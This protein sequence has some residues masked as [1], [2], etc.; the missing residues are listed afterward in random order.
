MRFRDARA[1]TKK[2][3]EMVCLILSLAAIFFQIWILS[4]SWESFFQEHHGRLFASL[5]FSFLALCVCLLTAWTTG[6]DFMKNSHEGRSTTYTNQKS[7][8]I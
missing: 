4:T 2:N 6:K 7:S 1:E 3:V 5:I 8:N